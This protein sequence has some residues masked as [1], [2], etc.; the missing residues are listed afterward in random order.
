MAVSALAAGSVVRVTHTHANRTLKG[1]RVSMG[2]EGGMNLRR[3]VIEPKSVTLTTG[4]TGRIPLQIEGTMRLKAPKRARK[5]PGGPKLA[6]VAAGLSLPHPNKVATGGEDALMIHVRKSGGGSI[7]VAD[8]VGGWNAKGVNPANYSRCLVH[9]SRNELLK[10]ARKEDEA[11]KSMSKGLVAMVVQMMRD[12]ID[13]RRNVSA[14]S[15]MTSAM[16]RAKVPGSATMVL[17]QLRPETGVLEVAN[18]GDAGLRVFRKGQLVMKTTDQQYEFDMP[19]QMACREFVD[20]DYN[21]PM[22]ANNERFN[23]EEGDWIIAGSDGLF[24]N[25][26]DKE[27]ATLQQEAANKGSEAGDEY[28]TAQVVARALA[29]RARR[30][31]KDPLRMVPYAVALE[32]EG[33]GGGG[34]MSSVLNH[35]RA[36]G[37]KPDDITVVAAR[38]TTVK[39]STQ[40]AL[41][42]AEMDS[43]I[44][45]KEMQRIAEESIKENAIR[46][47][48]KTLLS[49]GTIKVKASKK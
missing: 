26:F 33:T 38:V 32:A 18:L 6:L 47:V 12:G 24:D 25:M 48:P 1:A 2:A 13:A 36:V 28:F 11:A 22:D 21:T 30:Y 29:E 41:S 8:G 42:G 27:I 40:K 14:K 17:A 31:S 10:L 4:T 46:N 15:I 45:A 37:G 35:A 34:P 43:R 19:Y 49:T 16:K 9:F 3:A 39:K 7:A 23:V 5:A 20:M 44:A